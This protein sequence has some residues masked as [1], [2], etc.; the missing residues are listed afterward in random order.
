MYS[1][2]YGAV[3]IVRRTGGLDDSVVDLTDDDKHADGIKF[4]EYSSRALAKGIRKALVIYENPKILR[5]YRHNGMNADFSWDR[6]VDQ[7]L[8]VYDVAGVERSYQVQI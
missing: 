5:F 4:T 6:A 3:P 2:R 8:R 7:Y 1:L